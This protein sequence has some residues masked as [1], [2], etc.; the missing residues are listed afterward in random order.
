MPSPL[1][2]EQVMLAAMRSQSITLANSGA[3]DGNLGLFCT[4]TI[5]GN[6]SLNVY[7]I[8]NGMRGTLKVVQDAT[9]GRSLT[10]GNA[11]IPAALMIDT[12]PNA[13]T[14]LEVSMDPAT[15]SPVVVNIATVTPVTRP[16]ATTVPTYYVATT[17]LD[18][19]SGLSAAAPLL[20]I[21]VA[22]NKL[23]TIDC[24]GF[25]PII[26][27]AA[28][29]YAITS[30]IALPNLVGVASKATIQG[31]AGTIIRTNFGGA[32]F[33]GA[34]TTGYRLKILDLGSTVAGTPFFALVNIGTGRLEF[35][36]CTFTGHSANCEGMNSFCNASTVLF[37]G[38]ITLA[39]TFRWFIDGSAMS[40]D[41][42]STTWAGTATFAIFLNLSG[43][44][45][46]SYALAST[47]TF[48][49]KKH[50]LINSHIRN[51]GNGVGSIGSIV[52]T[53]SYPT[54]PN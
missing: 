18:T 28:G 25:D 21:Q 5:T 36:T 11:V 30:S 26:N 46:A 16:I 41:M 48:T 1:I 51:Y 7:N 50:E 47:G 49:G 9:G 32:C 42:S 45:V 17:G 27:V 33:I 12:A 44:N 2:N 40:I 4:L 35:E 43:C 3:W 14:Y 19:N 38:T 34:G 15:N 22:L 39:G 20:T 13:I 53:Y 52:G 6:V 23:K 29:T 37:V 10:F 31:V 8:P 54:A 24:N